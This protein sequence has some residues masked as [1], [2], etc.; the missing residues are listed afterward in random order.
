MRKSGAGLRFGDNRFYRCSPAPA[1]FRISEIKYA[2]QSSPAMVCKDL[3]ILGSQIPDRVQPPDPMG[4]VQALQCPHGQAHVGVLDHSQSAEDLVARAIQQNG[5]WRNR[6]AHA[7]KRG[8]NG[9]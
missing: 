6:R 3:A 9:A 5:S 8:P 1:G 7:N 4:Y 2:T